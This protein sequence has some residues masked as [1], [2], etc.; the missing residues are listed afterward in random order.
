V[1]I[2]GKVLDRAIEKSAEIFRET[3]GLT[4]AELPVVS[5]RASSGNSNASRKAMVVRT[6][7]SSKQYVLIADTIKK[8]AAELNGM[9]SYYGLVTLVVIF[10]SLSNG[11][12]ELDNLAERLNLLE[13]QQ[14]F[15]QS[16]PDCIKQKYSILIL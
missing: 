11:R 7:R 1:K 15:D 5:A 13:L 6:E 2:P 10:I 9:A 3:F 14:Q 12:I 4:L 8:P 16:L